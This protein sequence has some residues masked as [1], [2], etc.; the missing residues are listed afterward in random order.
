MNNP[1]VYV[2][3]WN[4]VIDIYVM[5]AWK[6]ILRAVECKIKVEALR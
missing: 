6:V 4:F 2:F 1:K 5:P 3:C